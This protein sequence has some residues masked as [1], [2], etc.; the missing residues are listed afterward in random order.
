MNQEQER[1]VEK[2][3]TSLEQ[4]ELGQKKAQEGEQH[5]RSKVGLRN[6]ADF[7]T[8]VKS[9]K[10]NKERNIKKEKKKKTRQ[11]WSTGEDTHQLW[12]YGGEGW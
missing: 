11:G 1:T 12:A 3:G 4:L 5:N 8:R 6:A 9:L 7:L 2:V 10:E